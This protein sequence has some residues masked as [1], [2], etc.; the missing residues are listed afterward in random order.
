MKHYLLFLL[1]FLLGTSL[2][3]SQVENEIRFNNN[4]H[5]SLLDFDLQ[6][7]NITG[8]PSAL[9]PTDYTPYPNPFENE[10][11]ISSNVLREEP[12]SVMLLNLEGK[13]IFI[14]TFTPTEDLHLTLPKNNLASGTYI[15]EVSSNTQSNHFKLSKK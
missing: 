9:T 13:I 6:T 10:V 2:L 3:Y 14:Q 15:I 1:T 4:D 12:V 8:I 5:L 7:E 11:F